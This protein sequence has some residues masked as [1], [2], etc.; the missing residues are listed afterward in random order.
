MH[1]EY[2]RARREK[3]KN[4]DGTFFFGVRTTGIFCRPSCP[5]PIAKEEN[6]EYFGTMFEALDRGFRPC[7]RCRPDVEVDYYNGNVDGASVVNAALQL[8]Y[9]GYL[10]DRSLADLAGEVAVS[11]RHLRKLFVDNLGVPP[12]KIARYHKALFAKKLLVS[13]GNSMADIAFASGFGSIR[14]FNDAIKDIFGYTPTQLRKQADVSDS[15]DNTTLLLRYQPPFHFN[16]IL[17]FM[18]LRAIKGVE[19][20]TDKSYSRTFRTHNTKGYFTV[21][22]NPAASALELSIVCDDIKCFMEVHNRVRRMFDLDTNFSTIN[23]RFAKDKLLSK[24]LE[25][26]HVPRLPAAFNPFEFLIR[27]ILG[28]QVTV[29]AAT[30]MAGRIAER[31]VLPTDD[32]FPKGLDWFFPNAEELDFM[33]LE[34]LGMT[35]TR[36][37]TVRTATRAVLDKTISLSTNQRFEDFHERLTALKGIGDWTA[38]YVG[39][40]GLGMIDSFPASDL[41]VIKAM[42]QNDVKP[43]LKEIEKR[44]QMWRPYRA[45]AALCLWNSLEDK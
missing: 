33:D 14:Q 17:D 32:T 28:Q 41:G 26:G 10:N 1:T 35:K 43:T 24:G 22:D 19:L 36:L 6:V 9:D 45:Y 37:Q 27:A 23:K 7:L 12:I 30:T 20:V 4:F 25:D 21:G 3:D 13:S 44:S 8:I 31:A 2:S 11:E 38:N 5:S 18:R 29:K 40:R 15:G 42:T 39:M 34:G 16:R